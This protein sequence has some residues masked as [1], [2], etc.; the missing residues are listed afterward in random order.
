MQE[1]WLPVVGFTGL[2]EVSDLGRV[3][4]LPRHNTRGQ[5]MAQTKDYAGYHR[6]YLCKK[7]KGYCRR[8]HRLVLESFTGLCPEGK[9]GCHRDDDK[10]NNALYNLV[11]D[12]HGKNVRDSFKNGRVAL[13]GSET[14]RAKLTEDTVRE[15]KSLLKLG[16]Y[17]QKEIAVRFSVSQPTISGIIRGKNWTHVL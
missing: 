12:E 7:S 16:E 8:A 4:S 1:N 9:E 6:V 15:I 14:G 3:R 17:S 10:S 13:R 11:W 5:I 2:Y